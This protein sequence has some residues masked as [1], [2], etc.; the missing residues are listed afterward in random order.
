MAWKRYEGAVEY[1]L[2]DRELKHGEPYFRRTRSRG[3]A[4]RGGV[5]MSPFVGALDSRAVNGG[6][7]GLA[8]AAPLLFR[9]FLL[10]VA[11]VNVRQSEA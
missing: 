1:D 8:L 11:S 3:K 9:G 4:R 2:R 6:T 5:I 10:T 7:S